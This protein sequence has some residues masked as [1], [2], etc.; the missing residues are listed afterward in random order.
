LDPLTSSSGFF[1]IFT[2]TMGP[3][4]VQLILT[5]KTTVESFSGRDQIE[6]ENSR[7]HAE[8]GYVFNDHNKRK[9]R[10]RWR[11]EFG[12]VEVDERWAVGSYMSRWKREMG[13][14]WIG[15]IC[16]STRRV[17]S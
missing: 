17:V 7:L 6:M 12:K 8:F 2:F 9:V 13:R 14:S 3:T 4:H 16:R 5:G 10:K 15:W 11:E 1:C